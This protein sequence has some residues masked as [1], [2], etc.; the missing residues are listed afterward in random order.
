MATDTPDRRF[1]SRRDEMILNGDDVNE[2]L[3]FIGQYADSRLFNLTPIERLFGVAWY[4]AYKPNE[5]IE[6][7]HEESKCTYKCQIAHEGSRFERA[8]EVIDTSLGLGDDVHILYPQAKIG[9]YTADFVLFHKHV[10]T[11]EPCN[12]VVVECDGHDFHEKTKQQASHDKKRDR[13]MQSRG[14][15]IARFSGSDI[16]R[17]ANACVS[18]LDELLFAR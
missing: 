15:L 13:F 3:L 6:R 2:L 4:M 7:L 12:V 5:I 17:D 18:E 1:N 8:S 14:F 9:P 11:E 16:W 10:G